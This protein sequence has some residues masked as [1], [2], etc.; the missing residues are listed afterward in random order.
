[1]IG[2]GKHMLAR[3]LKARHLLRLHNVNCIPGIELILK[4]N[5]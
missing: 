1:M 3:H 4:L 5:V 2:V